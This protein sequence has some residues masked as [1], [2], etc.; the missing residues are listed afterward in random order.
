MKQKS[1]KNLITQIFKNGFKNFLLLPF[2]KFLDLEKVKAAAKKKCIFR[3]IVFCWSKNCSSLLATLEF[4]LT[5]FVGVCVDIHGHSPSHF[6]NIWIF[7][8]LIFG[9]MNDTPVE[10]IFQFFHR[11][12][13]CFCWFFA[14]NFLSFLIAFLNILVIFSFILG[15]FFPE[16]FRNV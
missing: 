7:D 3:N 1:K 8:V 6:L 15:P 12:K 14:L 9:K 5:L 16:M 13:K 11:K 10:T 2:R 4:S